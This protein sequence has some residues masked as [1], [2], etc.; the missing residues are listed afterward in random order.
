MTIL[1]LS[2]G[3]SQPV[4]SVA[5]CDPGVTG[6]KCDDLENII[7]VN[8]PGVQQSNRGTWTLNTDL[9]VTEGLLLRYTYGQNDSNH[10]T[11]RDRDGLNLVFG[12]DGGFGGNPSLVG[13]GVPLWDQRY[14]FLSTVEEFSHE[15]Q[16]ISDL[17]GPINFIAGIYYHGNTSR[18]ELELD[19]FGL[20]YR[21]LNAQEEFEDSN[22]TATQWF[23]DNA[24]AGI[25]PPASGYETCDDFA[26]D[27]YTMVE[28]F[29]PGVLQPLACTTGSDHLTMYYESTAAETKTKAAFAHVDYEI[30]DRLTLS[31]GVRFTEDEKKHRNVDKWQKLN[32]NDIFKAFGSDPGV[33]VPAV[34][35]WQES[36]SLR[37]SDTWDAWIWNASAE[38][39]PMDNSMVYGRIAKGYRAGAFN[40]AVPNFAPPKVNEET[41]INYEIGFK[42]ISTDQRLLFTGSAFYSTYDDFQI[43][44]E[45]VIPGIGDIPPTFPRFTKNIDGT[46]IWGLELEGSYFVT[47][48][49]QLSG[50]YA[51]LD[52]EIGSHSAITLMDPNREWSWFP[53]GCDP[54]APPCAAVPAPVDMTGNQLPMQPN[55]KWAL[56]AAYT[57]PMPNLLGSSRPLGMLQFLTTY[58]YTGE[59]HP[60]IDNVPSSKINGYGRW[61]VR[62]TWTSDSGQWSAGLF[63]QNV[64]DEIGLVEYLPMNLNTFRI[65]SLGTLTDP[66]RYGGFIRCKL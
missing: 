61:D 65:P 42:T 25:V 19:N 48:D 58:S 33:H 35:S 27:M 10:F 43:Y 15:L 40:S 60:N 7:N 55:H 45:Y 39:T 20:E 28:T 6:N 51:Y 12:E 29:A 9:D 34:Y 53:E 56:T 4:P 38:Y 1:N 24:W 16:V 5:N 31:G 62:G 13:P 47:E 11:S 21:F 41:L 46:N 54:G 2:Y 63:V 22:A 32:I 50:Y 37:E 17:D 8:A 23:I 52:S 44:A 36:F 49:L 30:S 3:Y 57:V 66:R 59:R 26:T 64:L 18:W 14:K